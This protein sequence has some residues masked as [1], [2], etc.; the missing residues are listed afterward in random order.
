MAVSKVA[1]SV[2][3]FVGLLALADPPRPKPSRRGPPRRKTPPA[4]RAGDGAWV[5]PDAPRRIRELA[6]QVEDAVGGWPG[7]AD[8]LVAVAYWESRGAA[9]A[10]NPE[11]GPNAARGWFQ[12]RRKTANHPAVLANP[13]LLLDERVAVAMAAD[14]AYRHA[15]RAVRGGTPVTWGAIRRG[16]RL[17]KLVVDETS[18]ASRGVGQRFAQALSAVGLPASFADEPAMPNDWPGRDAVMAALA[19]E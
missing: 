7:F 1:L 4:P 6:A 5:D 13:D 14:L 2:A 18:A 9:D 8:F 12:I 17:P 11:G 3:A 16:W 15:L 10:V 19:P